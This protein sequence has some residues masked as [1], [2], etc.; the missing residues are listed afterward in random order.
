MLLTLNRMGRGRFVLYGT[1]ALVSSFL[2]L[3]IVFIGLL[4]FGSSQWLK[5]PPPGWTLKWYEDFLAD[6][7]WIAAILT[8]LK[9]G[10]IVMALSVAIG[11]PA[12]FAIVRGR[13]PGRAVLRAF[14]VS[15]MIVPVV[16]IAI[17]FY[18]VA[19]NL[20][21]NGTLLGLICGHLILA[22]PFSII[23]IT[24]ALEGFDESIEKAAIICGASPLKAIYRITLPSIK[25]G[26]FAGALFSFL[27]SW[28]DVVVSI[29]MSSPSLQTLPVKMWVTLRLD[30]SPVI[31]AA[32]TL[33]IVITI[34]VMALAAALRRSSAR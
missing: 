17:A 25:M 9:V 10:A 12:S 14:F 19:L 26:V 29:F 15:P 20:R 2:L 32:S 8:S 18:G 27:T 4:S 24:T 21:L 5:F 22:L 1:G 23:C 7:R 16:I 30:L 6:P 34:I 11:L 33:L 31:A 3:P 13:F 28:D